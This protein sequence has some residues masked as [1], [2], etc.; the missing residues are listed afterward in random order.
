VFEGLV[1]RYNPE[2]EASSTEDEETVVSDLQHVLS[3]FVE[4]NPRAWAPLISK[5]SL[6]TLGK[7]KI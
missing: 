5:W 1:S 3:G 7:R 6:D 2:A 4:A